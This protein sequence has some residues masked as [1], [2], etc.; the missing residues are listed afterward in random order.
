M[1]CKNA[2]FLQEVS[3]LNLP[4]LLRFAIYFCC[5]CISKLKPFRREPLTQSMCHVHVSATDGSYKRVQQFVNNKVY[6][7]SQHYALPTAKLLHPLFSVIDQCR[8][9]FEMHS[10][11]VLHQCSTPLGSLCRWCA[12]CMTVMTQV[13]TCHTQ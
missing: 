3:H 2:A 5:W 12:G 7:G 6:D 4:S 10:T 8:S 9:C 13:R 11:W 1:V